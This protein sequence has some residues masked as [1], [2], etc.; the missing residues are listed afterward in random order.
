M[1]GGVDERTGTAGATR[2]SSWS[3]LSSVVGGC[4]AVP[5]IVWMSWTPMP[6]IDIEDLFVI[7]RP[8]AT[9]NSQRGNLAIRLRLFV[10]EFRAI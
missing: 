3:V 9:A 2:L 1:P 10:A 7:A 4:C 8:I 6:E 5:V